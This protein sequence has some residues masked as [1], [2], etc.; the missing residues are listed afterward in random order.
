M[1]DASLAE[2]VKIEEKKLTVSVKNATE[3]ATKKRQ[4]AARFALLK[5]LIHS[6]SFPDAILNIIIC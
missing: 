2:N 3:K 6:L 5:H 1:V 4:K